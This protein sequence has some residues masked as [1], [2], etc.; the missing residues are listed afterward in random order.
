LASREHSPLELRRK[1]CARGFD[2]ED[3]ER[4]LEEL[5]ARGLLSEERMAEAYV[6]ERVRKGFGPLRIFREL[7]QRGIAE[8]IIKPHLARSPQEWWDLMSAAHDKRFGPAR[9]ANAK[10]RARRVRFL[11]YRGFPAELIG[12]FLH[13][14]DS[15]T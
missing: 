12:A 14:E 4:L 11:D 15:G 9:P 6:A 8:E 10:E 2:P 7:S 13:A 5:S 3:V 1:L